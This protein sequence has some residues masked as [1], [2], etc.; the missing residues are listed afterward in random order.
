MLSY[1]IGKVVYINTITI[2][3]ENNFRGF[4]IF[5]N[6]PKNFEI[7]KVYKI[8]IHEIKNDFEET[9]F[10]FLTLMEKIV[11][12]DLLSISGLGSRTAIKILRKNVYEL[13]ESIVVGDYQ[14]I[15]DNYNVSNKLGQQIVIN[16]QE[17]YSNMPVNSTHY[18]LKK[19]LQLSL[20]KL[21]YSKEEIT[22]VFNN[23]S[24]ESTSAINEL[25]EEAIKIL[26]K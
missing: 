16:L 2:T 12:K 13:R 18:K 26:N 20:I 25:I 6:A 11:F 5:T 3:V 15:I 17:K 21:G 8:Y 4:Q 1:I 23:L 10:G 22:L 9:S 14:S 19:D 7:G 24:F